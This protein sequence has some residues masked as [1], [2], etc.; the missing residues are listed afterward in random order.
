MSVNK[1]QPPRRLAYEEAGDDAKSHENA[2]RE[3][4]DLVLQFAHGHMGRDPKNAEDGT[5]K[6]DTHGDIEPCSMETTRLGR[7]D[8]DKRNRANDREGTDPPTGND[9]GRI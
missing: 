2:W 8:L 9:A 3:E 7:S 6:G 4:D 5:N 1:E